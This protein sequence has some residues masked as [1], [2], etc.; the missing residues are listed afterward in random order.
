MLH[1]QSTICGAQQCS[2]VVPIG[3][4]AWAGADRWVF[5]LSGNARRL[6]LYDH[7]H[8]AVWL[9]AQVQ[10]CGHTQFPL[11]TWLTC[12][13]LHCVARPEKGTWD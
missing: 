7:V 10:Y 12:V 5:R 9:L 11:W 4:S 3:M 2:C 8:A 13:R 6:R 1:V